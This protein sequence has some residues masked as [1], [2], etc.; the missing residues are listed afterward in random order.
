MDSRRPPSPGKTISYADK[1]PEWTLFGLRRRD[2]GTSDLNRLLIMGRLIDDL[3]PAV[4]RTHGI[5]SDC[6]LSLRLIVRLS[7]GDR[8]PQR[9]Q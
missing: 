6:V 2:R 1:L 5:T 7:T 4:N 9:R 3:V 8:D